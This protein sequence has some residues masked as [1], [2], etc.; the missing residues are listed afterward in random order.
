MKYLTVKVHKPISLFPFRKKKE[1][2]VKPTDLEKAILHI[3]NGYPYDRLEILNRVRP[4]T[5]KGR[6]VLADRS[7]T[8]KTINK[9]VKEGKLRDI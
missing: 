4:Y 7:L 3:C 5:E 9:L 1:E 8:Y 2:E 6:Q